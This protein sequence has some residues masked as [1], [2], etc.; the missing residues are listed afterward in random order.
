MTKEMKSKIIEAVKIA[1]EKTLFE[2]YDWLDDQIPNEIWENSEE[3]KEIAGTF[4]AM[5]NALG[6]W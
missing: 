3:W 4:Y 1:N 5:T 2:G 6:M